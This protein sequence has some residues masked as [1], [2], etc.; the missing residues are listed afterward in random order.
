M[1][2]RIRLKDFKSFVD[3]EVE[4]APLTLLVGANA[5]GKSN[6][7]DAIRCLQGL[8]SG[9]TSSEVLNG[10][11][12]PGPK[13]WQGIRGRAEETARIGARELTIESHWSVPE[14]VAKYEREHGQA[15]QLYFRH[16]I[17]Y[18]TSPAVEI[19]GEELI[20]EGDGRRTYSD[21]A[22]RSF[23]KTFEN[24]SFL[25]INPD[26]MHD[27]GRRGEPLGEDGRNVSGVLAE[28]CD[29]PDDKMSLVTWLAELCAPEIEGI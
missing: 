23:R 9:V 13:I 4:V 26:A 17:T 2:K 1:L 22:E 11:K 16:W 3:E 5:S 25:R 20:V 6:F 21:I 12:R 28:I 29:D 8:V 19:E 15:D 27:Y 7:L 10:E 18:R 14:S 24:I